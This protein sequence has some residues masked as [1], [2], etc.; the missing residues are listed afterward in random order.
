MSPFPLNS[1]Y[2]ARLFARC[3]CPCPYPCH[4]RTAHAFHQSWHFIFHCPPYTRQSSSYKGAHC[5]LK[6]NQCSSLSPT[7]TH[8]EGR[9]AA[10]VPL[11]LLQSSNSNSHCALNL[12]K[13]HWLDFCP[14]KALLLRHAR[15]A[16]SHRFLALCTAVSGSA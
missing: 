14:C 16:F 7:I 4:Y 12:T 6:S 2:A 1:L 13:K 10:D 5:F 8:S 11:T 3:P 15:E 9:A